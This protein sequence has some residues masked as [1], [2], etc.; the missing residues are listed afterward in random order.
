MLRIYTIPKILACLENLN[1]F[2]I[3]RENTTRKS[4]GSMVI[5]DNPVAFLFQ[6]FYP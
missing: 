2:A 6:M 4:R 5:Q 3:F 1:F